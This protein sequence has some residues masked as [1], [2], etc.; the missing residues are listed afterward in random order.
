MAPANTLV[1][2]T[3]FKKV[4]KLYAQ[5]GKGD[6][7]IVFAKVFSPQSGWRWYI[8]EYDPETG[9]AFGLVAG[10]EVE[11]GYFV[12]N[13]PS[14]P[15]DPETGYDGEDMQS[16]NNHFRKHGYRFPPYERD[17]HFTPTSLGWVRERLKQGCPP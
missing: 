17:L 9:K 3:A 15:A 5:D 8:T 14:D 16:H 12:L 4:P 7:A 13:D 6:D 2:K 1:T 10:H 11:L